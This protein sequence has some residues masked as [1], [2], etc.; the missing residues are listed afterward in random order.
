MSSPSNNVVMNI[1]STSSGHRQRDDDEES[2]QSIGIY[3]S[4]ITSHICQVIIAKYSSNCNIDFHLVTVIVAIILIVPQCTPILSSLA[5]PILALIGLIFQLL[6]IC[7]GFVYLFD[8]SAS[9]PMRVEL[10]TINDILVVE[11]YIIYASE[12]INLFFPLMAAMEKPDQLLGCPS[13]LCAGIITLAAFGLVV[14]GAG[15]NKMYSTAY[16]IFLMTPTT[17]LG[18]VVKIFA[19][20]GISFTYPLQL[21]AAYRYIA[22]ELDILD[23]GLLKYFTRAFLVL[24]TAGLA[25]MN[26][27][28]FHHFMGVLGAL[29]LT[30]L[31]FIVPALIPFC[32]KNYGRRMW[33]ALVALDAFMLGIATL[34]VG[35]TTN[36]IDWSRANYSNYETYC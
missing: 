3:L 12:G 27:L 23:K 34:I 30:V 7:I 19:A 5:L 10:P 33:M 16:F 9:Y 8:D 28:H 36:A 21:E 6:A 18:V 35:T 15:A 22:G 14:C 26:P 29:C 2:G 11:S 17:T 20:I 31:T 13:L 1:P 32:T 4:F 24:L 25:M